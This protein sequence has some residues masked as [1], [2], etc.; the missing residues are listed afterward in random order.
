MR[1]SS[2]SRSVIAAMVRLA[3][4]VINGESPCMR[5]A[6]LCLLI[7][8]GGPQIQERKAS[9]MS[10][11]GPATLEASK[12]RD[13]EPRE[14]KIRIWTDAGVRALPNWKEDISEQI[15]YASQLLTPLLGVRLKVVAWKDW[16]RTG[17][18]AKALDDLAT[19]DDGKEATW[20]I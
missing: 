7:A 2:S 3:R 16:D 12:P 1:S 14:A 15:D 20:V 19:A 6:L 10:K 9:D 18:P 17:E 4:A 11:L 8:C 5:V 13:G